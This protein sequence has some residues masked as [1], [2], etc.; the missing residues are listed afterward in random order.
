MQDLG[1][2]QTFTEKKKRNENYLM[3]IVVAYI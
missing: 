2:E 3:R 1:F